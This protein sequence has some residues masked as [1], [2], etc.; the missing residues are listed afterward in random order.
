MDE[1]G[2]EGVFV[3]AMDKTS[4]TDRDKTYRRRGDGRSVISSR[5]RRGKDDVV[6]PKKNESWTGAG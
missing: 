6:V 2:V 5:R 3:V 4:S 1:Q